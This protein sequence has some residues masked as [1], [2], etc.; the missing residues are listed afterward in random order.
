MGAIELVGM[1]FFARHGYYDEEQKIGARYGV[2][3]LVE[4]SLE[5][6][7]EKDNLSQTVDYERLYALVQK[8]MNQPSRLLEN[9]AHRIIEAVFSEFKNVVNIKVCVSKFNPPVGGLCK[10]ARVTLT[11]QRSQI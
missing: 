9:I 10:K 7:A 11:R 2:D 4:T 3:L 6:A 1:E 8:I 5:T